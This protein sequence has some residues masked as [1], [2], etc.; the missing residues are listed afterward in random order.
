MI[1]RLKIRKPALRNKDCGDDPTWRAAF[2]GSPLQVRKLHEIEILKQKF[3]NLNEGIYHEYYRNYYSGCCVSII[4]RRWRRLL[5]E[6]TKVSVTSRINLTLFISSVHGDAFG[7]RSP[8]GLR[9]WL[10]RRT[11]IL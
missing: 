6:Q 8:D 5:V 7:S 2:I 1:C 3:S 9:E 11:V 4:V 10:R